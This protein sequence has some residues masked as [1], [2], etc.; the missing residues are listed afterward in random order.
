MGDFRRRIARCSPAA[1]SDW[2]KLGLRRAATGKT[3]EN[4]QGIRARHRHWH[5]HRAPG[6]GSLGELQ[7][8]NE[9]HSV[10]DR[11]RESSQDQNTDLSRTWRLVASR[12]HFLVKLARSLPALGMLCAGS[13]CAGTCG[14]T[15]RTTN[16]LQPCWL[17]HFQKLRLMVRIAVWRLP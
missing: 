7:C 8:G 13:N 3:L 1:V 2:F 5:V 6:T 15:L 14:S 17:L 10:P 16:S 4:G 11:A 9:R 12:R